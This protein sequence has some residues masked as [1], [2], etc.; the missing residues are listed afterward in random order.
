M[1]PAADAGWAGPIAF[2]Q[3]LFGKGGCGLARAEGSD[4]A[5]QLHGSRQVE[6]ARTARTHVALELP[7]VVACGAARVDHHAGQLDDLY[8]LERA[9]LVAGG[10]RGVL[11]G[12]GGR[13]GLVQRW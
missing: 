12:G 2:G 9:G 6:C 11:G 5:R 4:V 7:H 8:R 3:G 10:L 1:D 13:G